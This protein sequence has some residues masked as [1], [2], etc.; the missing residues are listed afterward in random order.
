[1]IGL[2]KVK[3]D[4]DCCGYH[5]LDTGYCDNPDEIELNTIEAKVGS[6]NEELLICKGFLHYEE[7]EAK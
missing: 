6:L 7:G 3:C 1:M 2:P 4:W 5:N